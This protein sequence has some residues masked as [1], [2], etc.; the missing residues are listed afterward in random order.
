M[1]LDHSGSNKYT[2]ARAVLPPS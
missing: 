2:H 1:K